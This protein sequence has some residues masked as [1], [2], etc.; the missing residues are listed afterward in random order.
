MQAFSFIRKTIFK[1]SQAE[2]AKVA[3]VTQ[4]TVSRWESGELI[5]SHDEMARIREEAEKRNIPWND[6]WFFTAPSTPDHP[7]QAA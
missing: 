7:E 2:F 1:L 6:A 5:P 4:A 3:G